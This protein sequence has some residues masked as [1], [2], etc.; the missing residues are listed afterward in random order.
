MQKDQQRR[1]VVKE[2]AQDRPPEFSLPDPKMERT[3]SHTHIGCGL[4]SPVCMHE[5][6]NA[7]TPSTYK[8]NNNK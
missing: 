5:H 4:C 3:D 2:L 7:D 1:S 8:H 6:K